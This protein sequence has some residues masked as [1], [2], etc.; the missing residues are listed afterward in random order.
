MMIS[1]DTLS[2]Y[3]MIC[4]LAPILGAFTILFLFVFEKR[5]DTLT[6]IANKNALE[7]ELQK[8]K[9]DILSHK[10]EPHFFFN[11][12]NV[13]LGL[14]RLDRK[15][16]LVRSIEMFSQIMKRKYKEDQPL[17]TIKDEL[18]YTKAY[19][20][21]QKVRMSERLLVKEEIDSNTLKLKIP[22]YV[23]QTIT[24]N[25]FKHSFEKYEGLAEMTIKIEK[26]ED[27]IILMISNSKQQQQ[28][29][30]ERKHM[31]NKEVGIGLENIKER[32]K[33]LYPNENASLEIY[34]EIDHTTTVMNW[35]I[36]V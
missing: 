10:I 4:I 24:E 22:T 36:Q 25:C 6:T 23:I 20:E 26:R 34:D 32:L 2:L 30:Q 13:I 14:A 11:A 8:S 1:F 29:D 5:L 3:I 12:L 7:K 31:K 35:P 15:E 27:R 9:Y 17:S 28:I 18:E 19:L 33:L 21:I 16:D